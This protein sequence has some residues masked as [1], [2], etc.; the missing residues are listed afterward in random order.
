[1]SP[2]VDGSAVLEYDEKK[3][4]RSSV[5]ELRDGSPTAESEF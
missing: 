5:H 2:V 1:M 4:P 3:P